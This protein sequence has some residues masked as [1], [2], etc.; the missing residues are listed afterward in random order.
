MRPALCSS[1]AEFL[2]KPEQPL[3]LS[4]K[5]QDPPGSVC[6]GPKKREEKREEKRDMKNQNTLKKSRETG[7]SAALLIAAGVLAGA[8]YILAVRPWHTRWGATD[9]ECEET[10]PG[11]ELTPWPTE[12]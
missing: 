5:R 12:T 8:A 1:S 7:K 2:S 11:D 3:R 9:E 4:T 10:L 6:M